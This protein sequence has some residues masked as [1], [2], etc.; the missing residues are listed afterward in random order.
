MI[1]YAMIMIMYANNVRYNNDT[2][3]VCY[4][5]NNVC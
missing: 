5:N 1:L 3:H 4:D 2:V